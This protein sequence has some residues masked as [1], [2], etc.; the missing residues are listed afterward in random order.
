M[1]DQLPP[2]DTG[3][4][5]LED[6]CEVLREGAQDEDDLLDA[7]E[8]GETTL[9]NTLDYGEVLGFIETSEEGIRATKRGQKFGYGNLPDAEEQS[10][11]L[12]GLK[13][14][15]HYPEFASVADDQLR[16]VN[17]SSAVTKDALTR[18][19]RVNYEFDVSDRVLE[20]VATTFLKTLDAAGMGDHKLGRGGYPTR[21]ETDGLGDKLGNERADKEDDTPAP[22]KKTETGQQEGSEK[23]PTEEEQR[24]REGKPN[25][26]PPEAPKGD[27]LSIEIEIS[28]EDWSADEVL[29]I[30][31]AL[32]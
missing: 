6:V 31:E 9:D 28:S 27:Q 13:E 20:A 19:L 16:E 17:D 21:L 26:D 18:E 10:L 29:K 5:N 7:V 25:L 1:P 23:A 8:M 15:K 30:I 11:F 24:R 2:Y 14:A 4:S 32:N 22:T 3:P 12:S